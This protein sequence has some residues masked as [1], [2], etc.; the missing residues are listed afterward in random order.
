MNDRESAHG[1]LDLR[2]IRLSVRMLLLVC[3][4]VMIALTPTA[5]FGWK[6]ILSTISLL[7][8]GILFVWGQRI[9]GLSIVVLLGLCQ[10]FYPA[11]NPAQDAIF[12]AECRSNLKRLTFA[13]WD[14]EAE[15]GHFPP[16]YTVD[17][18]GNILHSWRVLLLP[19]LGEVELYNQIDLERPWNDPVN[20]PFQAR[21]PE[22]FECP[23]T[24]YHSRWRLSDNKTS[25]VVIVGELTAW[26]SGRPISFR[27][28]R[29]GTSNTVAIIESKEYRANWMSPA[30]P[31]MKSF[32]EN[33]DIH[34]PHN[35]GTFCCSRFDGSSLYFDPEYEPELLQ[36][37]LRA[38]LTIAGRDRFE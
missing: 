18:D 28:I 31:T 22:I 3:T 4:I 26:N 33:K 37:R 35:N 21:M 19:Y 1:A 30:S 29:D 2:Q 20:I 25:Y 11:I 36:S 9:L 15:H 23:A 12:R 7:F 5:Y 38:L 13:L 27:H 24:K 32:L 6:G 34:G 10:F 17:S 8:A 16:P 14:F